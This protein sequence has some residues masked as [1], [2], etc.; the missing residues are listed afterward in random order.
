[1]WVAGPSQRS[2]FVGL[3]VLV[4]FRSPLRPHPRRLG[5]LIGHPGLPRYKRNLFTHPLFQSHS[6]LSSVMIGIKCFLVALFLAA[7]PGVVPKPLNI[8]RCTTNDI[9]CRAVVNWHSEE[10]VRECTTNDIDC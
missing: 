2:I 1:M 8:V 7:I 4:V 5:T 9:D 3:V 6:N 10:I